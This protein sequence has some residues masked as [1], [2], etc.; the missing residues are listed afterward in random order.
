MPPSLPLGPV[1]PT[2]RSGTRQG[3][4]CLEA[5][6]IAAALTE[7]FRRGIRRGILIHSD[8]QGDHTSPDSRFHFTYEHLLYMLYR[9]KWP[10]A[11]L[12][13]NAVGKHGQ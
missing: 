6:K 5:T 3:E 7:S 11:T 8:E 4:R 13:V 2:L 12:Q 9:A 1:L 10:I